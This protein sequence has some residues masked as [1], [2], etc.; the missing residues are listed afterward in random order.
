MRACRA[1]AVLFFL[2]L[3]ACRLPA[4]GSNDASAPGRALGAARSLVDTGHTGAVLGLEFD[5]KRGLLFSGGDD[6]TVRIWDAAGTLQ[7]VLVVTQLEVERIAVNPAGTQLAVVVTDNS[8]AY[9]IS[10]WDWEAERQLYRIPLK[11]EPLFLRFSGMGTYLLHGESSWQGLSIV[12]SSDGARVEFHPEGFGIVGY[13]EMSRTEKTL[14]TYLVS[15]R[16]IYWDVASGAQT[17]DLPSVPYLSGIRISR[18]RRFLAGSN[19]REVVMVDTSTGGVRGRA[20][21]SGVLSLDIAPDGGRVS[22]AVVSAGLAMLSFTGDSLAPVRPAP[23][24]AVSPALLCYGNDALYLAD[25]RGGIVAIN[26][27]GGEARFA[28]NALAGITGIAVGPGTLALAAP[29]FVRVLQSDLLNGSAPP[30]WLRSLLW[31]N[32][33]QAATSLAFLADGRLLAWR[34]DAAGPGLA[35]FDVP[36]S[37][38]AEDAPGAAKPLLSGFR[39]PLSDLEPGGDLALGVEAGGVL[40]LVDLATGASRFDLRI[41]GAGAA[42][43]TSPSEIVAART[44]ASPADGSLIRVNIR[45]GETVAVRDQNSYTYSL[46]LDPGGDRP[47]LYTIGV[48][49]AGTTSLLRHDGPGFDHVTVLDSVAEEDLNGSVALDPSTHRLYAALGVDRIVAGDGTGVKP[50]LLE[51]TAPRRL[52]ARDGLVYALNKSGTVSVADGKTGAR[53]AEIYLFADGEWCVLFRD[54][55]YA[56]SPGGDVHARVFADGAPL[57]ATEDF[58]LRIG[59]R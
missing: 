24:P 19:G 44:A 11:E 29:A 52:A 17:L 18:D 47:A 9:F 42:V 41:P 13:A 23:A 28:G 49:L 8:G 2:L 50:L 30:S 3:A 39:A 43:Q 27:A 55:R 32:P 22:C 21:L 12:R 57:K 6:G 7:R 48:D 25:S 15:G 58:R 1:P 5:E 31:V 54:G 33:F 59:P 38:S 56:A 40:R 26:A 51:E 53:L 35:L 16:I 10:V 14:M 45:T 36:G 20:A 34:A 4:S 37:G 46:T